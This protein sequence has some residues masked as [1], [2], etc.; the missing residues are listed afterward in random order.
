MISTIRCGTY[1]LTAFI[2]S[3]KVNDIGDCLATSKYG[4]AG[5]VTGEIPGQEFSKGVLRYSISATTI[6]LYPQ[7]PMAQRV[8]QFKSEVTC[9]GPPRKGNALIGVIK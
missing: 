3:H 2:A 6:D 7:S 4:C 8:V 9:G 5:I 1:V